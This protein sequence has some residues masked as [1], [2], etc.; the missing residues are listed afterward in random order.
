MNDVEKDRVLYTSQNS[1]VLTNNA[2][3]CTYDNRGAS[4]EKYAEIILKE[5][6]ESWAVGWC[7]F[8]RSWYSRLLDGSGIA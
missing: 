1:V 4:D 5:L 3:R 6:N 7:K 2:W 8:L